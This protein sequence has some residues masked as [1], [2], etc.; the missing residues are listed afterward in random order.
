MNKLT[1]QELIQNYKN[2]NKI[3]SDYYKLKDQLGKK[4]DLTEIINP[5][6]IDNRQL[7]SPIDD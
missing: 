5:L 2:D 3:I 4:H 6:R 7:V 1:N